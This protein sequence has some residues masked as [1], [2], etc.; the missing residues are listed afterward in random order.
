MCKVQ[1]DTTHCTVSCNILN[2]T[3][4]F[5]IAKTKVILSLAEPIS[6]KESP[7]IYAYDK[8]DLALDRRN[9]A[10]DRGDPAFDK[11]D[12]AS[13]NKAVEMPGKNEDI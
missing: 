13:I 8:K 3:N 11:G 4:H 7:D 10:P 6:K 1:Q 2:Q 12:L 5:F 9:P